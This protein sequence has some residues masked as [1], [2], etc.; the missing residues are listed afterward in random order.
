MK[1]QFLYTVALVA[2]CSTAVHAN[3]LQINSEDDYKNAMNS[4]NNMVV[5][6]SADWCSVCNGINEP[7]SEIA[8]EAEF[9][10]VGFAKVNVDK[11]DTVS[12]QN[13]IVGVPT[14]LYV[15]GGQKKVEEIGVQN[16]PAFKDHLRDNLRKNFKLA[17]NDVPQEIAPAMVTEEVIVDVEAPMPAA[18]QTEPN[19]FMRMILGVKN[20]IM[21][22]FMKIVGFFTTI[23]DAIKGF[24]A[25]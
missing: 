24:F 3:V 16:M 19:F 8:Q 2:L 25:G 20:F 12:K 1:K 21:M 13:G 6:F 17:Q 14:F 23:I 18:K 7:F 22:I 4:N 9:K 15:E 11:L 10:N 5:E